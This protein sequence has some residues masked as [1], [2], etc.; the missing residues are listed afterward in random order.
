MRQRAYGLLG[1]VGLAVALSGC[2]AKTPSEGTSSGQGTLN[3]ASKDAQIEADVKAALAADPALKGEKITVSVK[4]AQVSLDGTV[5]SIAAHDEA[6]KDVDQ[7][8]QKYA[9]V[10]AGVINNLLVASDRTAISQNGEG[11]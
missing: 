11:R 8:V 9:S 6:E 5:K 7:V 2:S 1:I 10:N 4:D 3:N